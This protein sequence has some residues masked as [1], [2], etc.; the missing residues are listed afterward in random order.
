MNMKLKNTNFEHSEENFNKALGVSPEVRNVCRER[1]FFTHF[2]HS[3]QADELFPSRDEAPKQFT[4]VTGDL[5]SIL[6]MITDPLEYEF[7]LLHFMPYQRMAQMAYAKYL[8]ANKPEDEE[9]E[10]DLKHQLFKLVSKLQR[11]KE[12]HDDE[13]EEDDDDENGEDLSIKKMIA[14]VESVKKSRYNFFK[15]MELI[16][17]PINRNFGDVDDMING[18]FK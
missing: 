15:Y 3:L 11:L 9:D 4:T 16:G 18:I 5:Q 10:D 6:Q 1:I 7:T 12:E 8:Q 17:Q 2:T 13:D 14:R